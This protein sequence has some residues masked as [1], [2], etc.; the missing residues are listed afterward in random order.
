MDEEKA[1]IV[2]NAILQAAQAKEIDPD[3]N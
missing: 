2:S 1:K 3:G